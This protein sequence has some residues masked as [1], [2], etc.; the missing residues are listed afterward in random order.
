MSAVTTITTHLRTLMARATSR[1]WRAPKDH[2][3]GVVIEVD[4]EESERGMGDG[5]TRRVVEGAGYLR[6]VD[7]DL[8]V[9]A[10]NALELLLEAVERLQFAD[11]GLKQLTD[12]GWN[13]TTERDCLRAIIAGRMEAPTVAEAE[14]HEAAGGMWVVTPARKTISGRS[15]SCAMSTAYEVGRFIASPGDRWIALDAAGCPC[16]RPTV[17]RGK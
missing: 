11:G 15:W 9:G 2:P 16:A 5:P 6:E 17:K 1:P 13:V 14:A 10:V 3:H 4:R 12:A 7:A 8:I